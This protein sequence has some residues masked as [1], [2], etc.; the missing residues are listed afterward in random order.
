M[1][2]SVFILMFNLDISLEMEKILIV[3]IYVVLTVL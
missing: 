3:V 2:N 1:S